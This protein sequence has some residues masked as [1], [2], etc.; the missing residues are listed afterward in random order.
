MKNGT[1]AEPA[2]GWH[3]GA[4]LHSK[5]QTAP[6]P[7]KQPLKATLCALNFVTDGLAQPLE[8]RCGGFSLCYGVRL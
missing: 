1:A 7:T 6:M 2:L 5:G 3:K 4:F 8:R